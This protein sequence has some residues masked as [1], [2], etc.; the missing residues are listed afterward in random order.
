[1]EISWDISFG[2]DTNVAVSA[3]TIYNNVLDAIS[4]VSGDASIM[5]QDAAGHTESAAALDMIL[6]ELSSRGYV[7][8]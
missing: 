5:L 4:E 7:F 3:E 8:S 2:D 6:T 1:V